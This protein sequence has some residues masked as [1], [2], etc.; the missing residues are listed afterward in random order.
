MKKILLTIIT[1]ITLVNKV[2]AQPGAIDLTFS[3]T[4]SSAGTGANSAITTTAMQSDGKIIIGGNFLGYNGI[5]RCRIARLNANGTVDPTFNPG[6]GPN[7]GVSVTSIQSD[8]KII[9]GGSFT[10]YNGIVINRIARLNTNGTL[11]TTFHM[12]AGANSDVY[13][14]SIQSD[15]KIVIGGGF[16]SYNGIAINRIARLNTNGTIDT[17][18]NLG[19][20]ANNI[21]RA[22][23]ILSNGK[24]IIG[25][26]FITYNGIA[27]NRI[28]RLNTDG[29][30]DATFNPGTG[31]TGP[32]L[33]TSIQTDGKIIIGGSFIS[34]NGITRNG[35]ARLNSNGTLDGTFNPGTGL[36]T[37][38]LVNNTSIQA[39]GK[40]IIGGSFTAY[41]GT[42]INR[43][44]RLNINGTLDANFNPGTGANNIVVHTS[45]QTDG[46]I[47][48]GGS[49]TAYNNGTTRKYMVRLNINGSLDINFN[50]EQG[51]NGTIQATSIQSDGKI[52]IGGDFS[53]YN[54]TAINAIARLNADG[55]LD[56]TFNSGTGALLATGSNAIIQTISIQSDGKIIIGGDFIT[57]NGIATN[58]IAR[59]N[60]DGSLDATFN[61]GTGATGTILSTSIQSDGKI[62]I[63]GSFTSYNGIAINRIARLNTNGSLDATFNPGTG[64][65]GTILTTS[66]QSDGK[67][68]IGG[69]FTSYNGIAINRIARLNSNGSLD[70]TFISVNGANNIVRATSIQSDGKIIIGGGFTSYNGIAIN[71]IARLNTNGSLDATFNPGTGANSHVY[72]A[73]ILTDGKI[74]IGG[75]FT[76]YNGITRNYIA[77]IN[78]DGTLDACFNPG[79][80]VQVGGNIDNTS[81]QIDGK[82][83]IGGSFSTYDGM[84]RKSIARIYGG[85]ASIAGLLTTCIGLSTQLTGSDTPDNTNA[86]TSANTN[87]ASVS[88]TGLLTGVSN[89]T[90][91]LTYLTSY[92]CQA[93]STFTVNPL[94]N[95][96][97]SSIQSPV[98]VNNST[99]QLTGSPSGGNYSGI[100][101]NGNSF[102]PAIA[103]VGNFTVAY[104]YTD[105]NNCSNS[106]SQ[107]VSVSLCTGIDEVA[108]TFVSIYP[109]PANDEL[110]INLDE[111]LNNSTIEL[112]DSMGKLI[113]NEKITAENTKLKIGY[114]PN[115]IYSV[116]VFSNGKQFVKRIIKE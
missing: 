116:R 83:I 68:I 99:I 96:I 29:S 63:G 112:Y 36:N 95:V 28:A 110:S 26:S 37:N 79:T 82:I 2:C 20:G 72:N 74:I 42:A 53:T 60:T 18:F 8:G 15:G 7:G 46:K 102:D 103:G 75:I 35:I 25:G 111:A 80:G 70:G 113:I 55:S 81:I 52:I 89:G 50:P 105:I 17:T 71:C 32:I 21:V 40:I 59:L 91:L 109:N 11:D 56:T 31:A 41:N 104:N 12:G 4:D 44:A 9:I 14:T 47:I 107:T 3:T 6:T 100:G 39:D 69:S 85:G 108:N 58:R 98:C 106:A 90:V 48:I 92:S 66:I 93:T 19:T 86:W 76:T 65:T 67:I 13:A 5:T 101:V 1:I 64:A 51:V 57:Y 33:A 30:L 78:T 54:E 16:T 87:I 62:I 114:L 23:S 49:F 61:P 24:I 115:G 38:G 73:S 43:I 84:P 97:F 22:T 94:P 10:Y 34:Y 88:S 45:I 77:R 27:T